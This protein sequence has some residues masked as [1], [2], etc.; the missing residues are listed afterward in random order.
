[1]EIKAA[2]RI[3]VYGPFPMNVTPKVEAKPDPEDFRPPWPRYDKVRIIDEN[4]VA[5]EYEI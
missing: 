2:V 4:G 5:G 3:R 1:M